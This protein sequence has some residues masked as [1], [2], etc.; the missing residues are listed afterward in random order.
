MRQ[1]IAML[2]ALLACA[3]IMPAMGALVTQTNQ[4]A[5]PL[6]DPAQTQL[7]T[8]P[9]MSSFLSDSWAPTPFLPEIMT[10]SDTKKKATTQN[11][12]KTQN[13]NVTT[14]TFAI[15]NFLSD[16]WMPPSYTPTI[17]SAVSAKRGGQTEQT[18]LAIEQFLDDSWT[19]STTAVAV[20]SGA[21][22]TKGK[23]G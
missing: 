21:G 1:V 15:Q 23:M 12:N 3:V 20:T 22:Y 18:G 16:T 2:I 13:S 4:T 14:T 11:I 7:I 8:T 9:S 19:P 17:N 10:L 5:D 6:L